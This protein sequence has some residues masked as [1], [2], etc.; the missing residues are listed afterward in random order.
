MLLDF[1]GTSSVTCSLSPS[2][3]SSFELLGGFSVCVSPDGVSTCPSSNPL[4]AGSAGGGCGA[5]AAAELVFGSCY[6]D[7]NTGFKNC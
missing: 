3:L 2:V 7:K 5:T 4:G 6:N 1:F